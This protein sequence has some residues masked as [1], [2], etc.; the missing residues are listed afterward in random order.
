MVSGLVAYAVSRQRNRTRVAGSDTVLTLDPIDDATAFR[1]ST[2][3]LRSHLST[4]LYRSVYSLLLNSGITSVVGLAYWAVAA[5]HYPAADIGRASAAISAMLLLSGAAQCNLNNVLP[6]L[7]PGAG[8]GTT[9]LVLRSYGVAASLSVILATGFV[10]L[11]GHYGSAGGFVS[12]NPA[13]AAWFVVAVATWSVFFLEDAVLAGL[14]RAVW[15]PIENASFSVGKVVMLL[16]L[17]G[18]TLRFGVFGSFTIPVA[19]AII[20]V[21][22]VIFTRFIPRHLPSPGNDP[23][24]AQPLRHYLAGEY[25]GGLANLATTTLLPLLASRRSERATPIFTQRGWSGPR[26]NMS[27]RASPS[28]SSW[29]APTTGD[30]P[31]GRPGR[32]R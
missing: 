22:S 11:A 7:V 13:Y 14:R 10:I 32:A 23:R 17:A 19:I 1:P 29:K 31:A 4:P 21:N 25:V 15:V 9:R 20:P 18:V 30:G 3:R 16:A 24:L 8:S 26:S 12:D 27:W 6:R 28:H 2:G 5:H